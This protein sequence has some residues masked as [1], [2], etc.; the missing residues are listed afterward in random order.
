[1]ASN[2]LF[3]LFGVLLLS[4]PQS[5]TTLEQQDRGNAAQLT[6]VLVDELAGG[7]AREPVRS[8][9]TTPV[10]SDNPVQQDDGATAASAGDPER[11]PMA[12]HVAATPVVSSLKKDFPGQLPAQSAVAPDPGSSNWTPGPCPG[13]LFQQL[14]EM[15]KQE[16]ELCMLRQLQADEDARALERA[17]QEA[18]IDAELAAIEKAREKKKRTFLAAVWYQLTNKKHRLRNVIVVAVIAL[19]IWLLRR[20]PASKRKEYELE[21]PDFRLPVRHPDGTNPLV[22]RIPGPPPRAPR[23]ETPPVTP[24]GFVIDDDAPTTPVVTPSP[25]VSPRRTL[26]R[27]SAVRQPTWT[28]NGALQPG[29]PIG[30]PPTNTRTHHR[31]PQSPRVLF[32]GENPSTA[33][34]GS[35]KASRARAARNAGASSADRARRAQLEKDALAAVARQEAEKA[36]KEQERAAARAAHTA[37]VKAARNRNR[38]QGGGPDS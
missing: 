17:E 10:A 13:N 28:P 24:D 5:D 31:L 7:P 33:Q 1:M 22:R 37:K 30:S 6:T 38:P 21:L 3:S 16:K 14:A 27:V 26:P 15:E 11:E 2:V 9:A 18:L 29:N 8:P 25:S 12:L 34:P 20:K 35:T 19:L 32:L 36:Q 4:G 23:R